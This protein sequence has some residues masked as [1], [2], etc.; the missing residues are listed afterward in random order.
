MPTRRDSNICA[1]GRVQKKAW[2]FSRFSIGFVQV[3]VNRMTR[4]NKNL[5]L[6]RYQVLG[7]GYKVK[8][9][10]PQFAFAIPH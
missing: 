3:R 2:Y 9:P 1:Y 8:G 10:R 6:L 4:K 7:V 5:A